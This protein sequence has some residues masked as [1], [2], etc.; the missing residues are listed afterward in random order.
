MK[1]I[2]FTMVFVLGT[3][4]IFAQYKMSVKKANNTT[5]DIWVHDI[6]NLTFTNVAFTCGTS[7]ITY[8]GQTY[9]TVVIGSQCW[10]KENLNL[11]I[12]IAGSTD[13]TNNSTIE[14]YCYS[15]DDANCTAYGGLY[16]WAEAVQY[17]N[18]ATNTTSPSP[19]FSGNVQGICPTGWHIP[20]YTEFD[21]L[22]TT[23]SNDGNALKAV[24]QG[25]GSGVGT[26]TSGFS[27]LLAGYRNID[28]SFVVN[29]YAHFWSSTEDVT[30]GAWGMYLVLNNSNVNYFPFNK[31]LGFSV[32]CI[33]D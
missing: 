14:K 2:L 16:Q 30:G 15:D 22:T 12:R 4:A 32:R 1:K 31:T 28:N 25:T 17:L 11:G 18:G 3:S 20:T 7:T 6:I 10:L 29:D 24:G 19:A 21:T 27:A 33:K 8:A 9:T 26:N 5:E 13:Q 23:V